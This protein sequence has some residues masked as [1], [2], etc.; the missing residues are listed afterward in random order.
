MASLPPD[1]SARVR[2]RFVAVALSLACAGLA[3]LA[4]AGRLAE[5]ARGG[6][7]G[8]GRWLGPGKLGELR[9]QP[10]DSTGRPPP[11]IA[12]LAR[13]A[14]PVAPLAYEPFF[15]AGSAGFRASGSAGSARDAKLLREAL[16]RNPR[17]REARTLLLRHALGTNQLTPAIEQLAMLNRLNPGAIEQL[18]AAL[19]Q[20]IATERQA[21]DA[22]DALRPYPELYR[23]FLRG[24]LTAAK[25]PKLAIAL[26]TR[27]PADTFTDPQ[28]R[29]SA[30]QVMVRA[31]AF[32]AARAL[33]GVGLGKDKGALV[34]S[35]E[36]ADRRAPPPFNWALTVDETGAAEPGKAGGLDVI[37]YGRQPGTLVRQLLT[38]GPGTYTA[39]VEY[40]TL[41]G[42]PGAIGL[43]L[44]CAGADQAFALRPLDAKVEAEADAAVTFTVPAQGCSGQMLSLV[45]RALEERR[46]QEM[47]VRRLDV[48]RGARP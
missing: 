46:Q 45:G 39:R 28:V 30:I 5:T 34:H 9:A 20:T 13:Q 29:S 17:S 22:V 3:L 7:I 33:W 48:V 32:A 27:L 8:L 12:G 25:E 36:F 16:R 40:R 6:Q 23:P 10:F 19:G 41:S 38:L 15:G 42:Q 18:M 26:V 35:P 44:R 21:I 43:E 11:G 47:T 37:Y 2:Q 1:R 14:L 4:N 31:Q 24:F